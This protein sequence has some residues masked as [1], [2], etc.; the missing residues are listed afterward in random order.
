MAADKFF[1]CSDGNK[2]AYNIWLPEKGTE[3]RYF[4]QIIHGMVEHSSRYARFAKVLNSHGIAV[5]AADQRGHG[6]TVGDGIPGH[7]GDKDGWKSVSEDNFELAN[8]IS[9]EYKADRIFLLGHSMGSFVARVTMLN[10]PDF[11]TGVVI[12]GTSAGQGLVG[13]AG[14]AMAKMQ[15]RFKGATAKGHTMNKLA[16]GPYAKSV[17]NAATGFDW[18]SSDP[19]EVQKYIDDPKCG[20]VCTNRFYL[21]LLTMIEVAN[22][23]KKAATLPKDLPLLIISG[24][25]DPVGAMGKGVIKVY[26]LYTKAGIKD[27]SLEIIKGAR[28]EILN[29]VM[30]EDV[31]DRIIKWMDERWDV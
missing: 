15:I 14:K 7:L 9:T 19:A 18:L 5:F 22:S 29:E 3:I 21:D 4:L 31:Y 20:F 1:T 27:V 6:E 11:Y 8:Y 13:K 30:R 28:H 12:M 17:P 16:F 25:E 24:D 2:L 10:H 23:P 26:N